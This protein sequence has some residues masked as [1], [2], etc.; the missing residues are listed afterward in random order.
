M[1]GAHKETNR[2]T[3]RKHYSEVAGDKHKKNN[4]TFYRLKDKPGNQPQC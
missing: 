4:T 3:D 1:D 2:H